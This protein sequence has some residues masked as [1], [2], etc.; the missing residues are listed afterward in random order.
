MIKHNG[1]DGYWIDIFA[2]FICDISIYIPLKIH[3]I[4]LNTN[5]FVIFFIF[6]H[7]HKHMKN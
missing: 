4:D 7:N 5:H 6:K 3:T 2:S 1:F